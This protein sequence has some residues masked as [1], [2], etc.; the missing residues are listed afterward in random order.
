M[1][2]GCYHVY[3]VCASSNTKL[4]HINYIQSCFHWT[5]IA[6][7]II[8]ARNEKDSSGFNYVSS[9]SYLTQIDVL[10]YLIEGLGW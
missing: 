7:S 9:K 4:L 2:I 3:T 6:I 5:S 1:T 8:T 10:S